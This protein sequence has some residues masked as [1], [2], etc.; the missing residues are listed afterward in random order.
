MKVALLSDWYLP[1]LGGLEMHVYDL[2]R[3]LTARGCEV[4]VL[5][6][7]PAA[8][9]AACGPGSVE[10]APIPGVSIQRLSTPLLPLPHYKLVYTRGAFG[11]IATRLRD[12]RFDLLHCMVSI[13]S[14]AATGGVGVGKRLGLP[15]VATFHSMLTGFRPVLSALDR[16]TG[17]SRWPVVFSAVSEAV[18]KDARL[19]LP[20][21]PVHIL[22][23]GVDPSAWRVSPAPRALGELRLVS[24][25]RLNHRK[26][27][28]ALLRAVAQARAALDGRVRISLTL[29][30]E[31]PQRGPLRALA[32]RLGLEDAIRFVGHVPREVVRD[33]LARADVFV[34]ASL[35]ESFGIAALEA[36]AAGLP[37]VALDRGGMKEFLRHEK[38]ALLASDD[39][40]LSDCLVRLACDD[41][42][43]A[44]LRAG[45]AETPV[46]CSWQ[47]SARKHLEVYEEALGCRAAKPPERATPRVTAAQPAPPMAA[48]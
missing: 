37:V 35:L 48:R 18:A 9:T 8:S 33:E 25:M 24:V 7:T 15:T 12:G 42:L 41:L 36:R 31:G 34:L 17:W 47:L 29:V 16:L 3:E 11:E 21:R 30:G 19:L 44:R 10:P 23:N 2:S 45:A 40:G 26:R 39:S 6:P 32:R 27:G 20:G 43:L 4:H 46:P 5:T 13:I 22:P 38:D 1:R 28:A 14:P